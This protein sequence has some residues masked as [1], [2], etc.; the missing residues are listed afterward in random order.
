MD[1]DM[2]QYNMCEQTQPVYNYA[3]VKKLRIGEMK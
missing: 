1:R 2:K 3:I